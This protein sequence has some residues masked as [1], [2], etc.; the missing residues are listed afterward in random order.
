MPKSKRGAAAKPNVFL[1]GIG[2]ALVALVGVKYWTKHQAQ[3]KGIAHNDPAE[4]AR[5]SVLTSVARAGT[6]LVAVGEKGIVLISDDA[7]GSW[8]LVSSGQPFTLSSVGFS[9]ERNGVAAGH[10][11]TLLTTADGGETWQRV[12]SVDQRDEGGQLVYAPPLLNVEVGSGGALLVTGAFGEVRQSQDGGKSW[13]VLP[14]VHEVGDERHLYG[15]YHRDGSTYFAGELGTLMV[16]HGDGTPITPLPSP[17][18]GTFFGVLSRAGG[19][20]L[21]Y[22]MG[23]AV[24][25]SKDA[26]STWEACAIPTDAP[27]VA[28]LDAASGETLLADMTGRLYASLQGACD[29]TPLE[30]RYMGQLSGLVQAD[31]V[32]VVAVGSRGISAPLKF[33]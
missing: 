25:S 4:L 23:G 13:D 31:D 32:H 17:Y 26:G 6:R 16:R 12:S 22:G 24:Y 30:A 11:G 1:I 27:V 33:R 21:A 5:H 15:S 9:D 19:D 8:K 3:A 20:L 29:F 7:G 14:G 18:H 2:L 10:Q 28:G